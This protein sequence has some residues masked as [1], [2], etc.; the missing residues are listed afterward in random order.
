MRQGATFSPLTL[1][2][3][4]RQM[5][6]IPAGTYSMGTSQ[7]DE[8]EKPIQTVSVT[9]FRMGATPV[10]VAMWQEY[11]ESTKTKMPETPWW[12]WQPTHPIVNVSWEDIQGQE[13]GG[14][15]CEWASKQAGVKLRLPT[16]GQFEY[17]ARGGGKKVLYPW[18]DSFNESKLWCST[19]QIGDADRTSPVVREERTYVNSFGL[20]DMSG[21]VLQWCL[22]WYGPYTSGSVSALTGPISGKGRSLRGG[23]WYYGGAD[24]FRCTRRFW[25]PA[26]FSVFFSGF[27]IC[28]GS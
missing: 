28:T 5:R 10:T 15:Y 2:D 16:E 6:Q 24:Y 18:G 25:F 21:N 7:G 19:K 11:C 4:V 9:P 3:Y 1:K 12:G 26:K 22:N 27:R 17:C 13:G 8:D 23:S 20:S 14:G